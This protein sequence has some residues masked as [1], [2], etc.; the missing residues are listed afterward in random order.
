MA[1]FVLVHGGFCRGW[2]WDDTAAALKAMG[3]RVEVVD[4]PSSGPDPTAGGGLA[5]DVETVRRAVD[6]CGTRVVLVGHSATGIVLAE[7]ADHPGVGHSV[8]LAALC[9][10]KGQSLADVLGGQ[11]PA[12]MVLHPDEGVGRVSDNPEV[13]RQALCADVDEDRFLRE[14][15]PRFVASSLQIMAETSSAPPPGHETTYVICEQDQVVPVAAREA[16][17]ARA[18]H[19]E[20]LPSSHNPQLSMPGRLAEVLD[21]AARGIAAGPPSPAPEPR[22]GDEERAESPQ[23]P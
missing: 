14:V 19:V 12:W 20:R 22:R 7:L 1:T 10:Q 6:A 17:S 11:I 3:H 15:Y 23:I 18:D 9:P 8:Y 13:V 2:V 4:L 5:G 16:M 21:R